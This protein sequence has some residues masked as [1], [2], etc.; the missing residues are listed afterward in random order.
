MKLVVLHY[1]DNRGNRVEKHLFTRDP[2]GGPQRRLYLLGPAEAATQIELAYPGECFAR[3]FGRPY[4]AE[5][6]YGFEFPDGKPW[7]APQLLELLESA[8]TLPQRPF[9]DCALALDWYKIPDP[10]IDSNHWANTPAGEL[11]HR[12]K[13]Y[14]LGPK[15]R[16]ARREL[17]DNLADVVQ[18]HPLYARAG[19]VVSVPGHNADGKGFGEQL[20]GEIANA[21][22]KAFAATESPGGPRPQAKEG[23]AT[24]EVYFQMPTV[25]TG[26]VIVVDDVW[27]SGGSMMAVA[28]AA[29]LAGAARVF[30]LVAV[31]TM[32]S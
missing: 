1:R 11:I 9:L 12:G 24:D 4:S 21:T 32:R 29:R 19:T 8:V 10:E 6:N 7:S 27:R 17:V 31:R 26:E 5:Y 28:Q 13:Y 2:S 3:E 16:A 15:R 18:V 20:A 25:L 30:G 23:G 14:S 22:G